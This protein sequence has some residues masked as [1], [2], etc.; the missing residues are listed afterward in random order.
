MDELKLLT[1][2]AIDSRYAL[3]F[4]PNREQAAE[5][6]AMAERVRRAVLDILP[7]D[8]YPPAEDEAS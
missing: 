8:L 5:A 7:Q 4:W 1:T 6:L 3:E 2:Y